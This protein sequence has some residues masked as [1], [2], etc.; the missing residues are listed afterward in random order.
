LPGRSHLDQTRM[1]TKVSKQRAESS[2]Q[3]AGGEK[4]KRVGSKQLTEESNQ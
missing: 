1:G 3:E 2:R 4:R